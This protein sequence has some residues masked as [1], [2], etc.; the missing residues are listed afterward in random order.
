MKVR[1][2]SLLIL[3]PKT[4]KLMLFSI[5]V[6]SQ[7]DE[8]PPQYDSEEIKSA[9]SISSTYKSD[10]MS[11]S[12]YGILPESS[13]NTKTTTIT[14]D[15]A[16][17]VP[18]PI[19]A[20]KTITRTYVE[21]TSSPETSSID[22]TRKYTKYL[23]DADLDFEKTFQQQTSTVKTITS[24]NVEPTFITT[25]QKSPTMQSATGATSKSSILS[26]TNTSDN[27]NDLKS[28]TT[29]TTTTTTTV[30]QSSS[31]QN[32]DD[33]MPLW[34]KPLGLPSP[35]PTPP[36]NDMKTTPKRERKT[37]MSKNKMNNEKNLQKRSQSPMAG[38][39]LSPIY[40]DLAYVPHHGNSQYSHVEFFK[41]IRARYY[42]FSGTEPSREVYNALLEAKQTWEDKSL[43]KEDMKVLVYKNVNLINFLFILFSFVLQYFRSNNHSH[44]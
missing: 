11:T 14:S 17:S 6:E 31:S 39:K 8:I 38:K 15:N 30:Q 43:G 20:S 32:K 37:M 18:I 42:V 5:Q 24:Q 10:P 16:T 25:L 3:F 19:S 44:V 27:N 2:I 28:S 29:T 26:S 40:M 34:D 4:N 41:K 9:I 1:Y 35:A 33:T 7:D 21:Y 12:F 36:E 22:S 13:V 23:D